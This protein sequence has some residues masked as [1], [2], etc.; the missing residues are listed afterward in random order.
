V[1]WIDAVDVAIELPR[2]PMGP[3]GSEGIGWK[4]GSGDPVNPP[5]VPNG[6]YYLD[7]DSGDVWVV[8]NGVWEPTGTSLKGPT[9]SVNEHDHDLDYLPFVAGPDNPLTG[10]LYGNEGADFDKAI[11]VGTPDFDAPNLRD[12]VN[13]EYFNRVYDRVP[14]QR[15]FGDYVSGVNEAIDTG[16]DWDNATE[17]GIYQQIGG[18]GTPAAGKSAPPGTPGRTIGLVEK[19]GN[20]TVAQTVVD[21]ERGLMF[22]RVMRDGNWTDWIPLTNI[23][24]EA[25]PNRR[26]TR[27]WYGTNWSHGQ[28]WIQMNGP[29]EEN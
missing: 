14:L 22:S 9:G 8:E 15:F 5:G 2:G 25:I 11:Q 13:V 4:I 6:S 3:R 16:H 19:I 20:S 7:S 17:Q 12:A 1:D 10:T 23:V 18:A 28:V 27:G 21:M 29:V 24:S 26:G